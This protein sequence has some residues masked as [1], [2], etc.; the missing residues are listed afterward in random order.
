[1]PR[2]I[3]IATG[4]AGFPSNR[5]EMTDVTLYEILSLLIAFL[6]LIV[7]IFKK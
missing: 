6:T 7:S 4:G 2:G 5:R 1:M 3:L